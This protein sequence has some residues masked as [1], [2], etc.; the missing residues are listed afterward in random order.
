MRK[1]AKADAHSP[2]HRLWRLEMTHETAAA[3]D[4]TTRMQSG[5]ESVSNLDTF[6][7]YA[8]TVTVGGLRYDTGDSVEIVSAV[9]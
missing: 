4:D 3:T 2:R 9:T 1:A 8:T 7:A 6:H 5:D